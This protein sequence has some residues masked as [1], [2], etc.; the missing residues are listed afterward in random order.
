MEGVG[1]CFDDRY[2]LGY[3]YESVGEK[4][5]AERW[6]VRPATTRKEH[7]MNT[8]PDSDSQHQERKIT[9]QYPKAWRQLHLLI[10]VARYNFLEYVH[11]DEREFCQF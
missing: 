9:Y 4:R 5:R 10:R 6:N 11:P 7:L 2:V 1:Y 3:A 8:L